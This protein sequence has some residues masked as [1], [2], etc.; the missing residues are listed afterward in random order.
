LNEVEKMI[1]AEKVLTSSRLSG[2]YSVTR[3]EEGDI[4]FK[5]PKS[6]QLRLNLSPLLS[7]NGNWA[8]NITTTVSTSYMDNERITNNTSGN[9]TVKNTTWSA[10]TNVSY[11]FTAEKGIKMPFTTRKIKFNNELTADLGLSYEDS[12]STTD[13][14]ADDKKATVDVDKVRFT[15]SPSA[16]YKFSKNIT[17]GLTCSYDKTIDDKRGDTLSTFQLSFFVEVL[18]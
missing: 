7:W 16:N 2:S 8:N 10:S 12:Y 4:D 6:E 1:H 18:F 9:I 13:N 17:G 15:I 14:S 5:D 3:I 11:T